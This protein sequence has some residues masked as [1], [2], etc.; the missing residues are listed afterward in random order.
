V[1]DHLK[2]SNSNVYACGDIC[3]EYKFTH[4]S[5]SMARIVIRNSMFFDTG[6]FSSLIIPWCTYTQPEVAHVGLYEHDLKEK[7]IKY[8]T[9]KRNFQDVDRA[10]LEEETEG[11]VKIHV[12]EGTDKIIGATIVGPHAGDM[13]SEITTA[14]HGQIGLQKLAAVIHPY[15]TMAEGIRQLGDEFNRTRLTPMVKV[16]F[17][18]L[19]AYK[20][21]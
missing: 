20:R 7:Q 8:N 10:I 17:R 9:F 1:D 5:D 15:P 3:T 11:F 2:T 13:I 21:S 12:K 4:M 19:M 6:K 18:N 14:M 16:L